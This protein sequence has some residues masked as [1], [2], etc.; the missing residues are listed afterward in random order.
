[1]IVIGVAILI[2][3]VSREKR[4][5]AKQGR[6]LERRLAAWRQE[7]DKAS[8]TKPM[9]VKAVYGT[10]DV[11]G[12]SRIVFD[13]CGNSYRLVVKFNY[14]AGVARVLFAGTR[15]EYDGIEALTVGDN[16]DAKADHEPS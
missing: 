3:L 1:M 10:A 16:E 2:G 8:W 15:T 5:R 6:T 12:D 11:I 7:V 9:E 14:V 4:L 13:I